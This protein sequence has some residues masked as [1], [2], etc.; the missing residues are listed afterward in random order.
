VDAAADTRWV[1]LYSPYPVADPSTLAPR[2]TSAPDAA[3]AL[4]AAAA[5]ISACGN[6]SAVATFA[7][8]LGVA[9]P[10]SATSPL[11]R[12]LALSEL[13]AATSVLQQRAAA[14]LALLGG[15]LAA[16]ALPAAP[17]AL[18]TNCSAQGGSVGAGV[19]LALCV[20]PDSAGAFPSA[21]DLLGR[22]SATFCAA[23]AGPSGL[24]VST[25]GAG[26]G[27][28]AIAVPVALLLL[29][30]AG[31]CWGYAGWR[32]KRVRLVEL[33]KKRRRLSM[34][35]MSAADVARALDG[36]GERDG[37]SGGGVKGDGGT[38]AARVRTL[39]WVGGRNDDRA[40]LAAIASSR[41]LARKVFAPVRLGGESAA[42]NAVPAEAVFSEVDME[43]ESVAEAPAAVAAEAAAVGPT[44]PAAEEPA[45]V[46]PAA[47]APVAPASPEPA[48]QQ[49][50]EPQ[51]IFVPSPAVVVRNPLSISVAT[52]VA[53]A[54]EEEEPRRSR[55]TSVSEWGRDGGGP[56]EVAP[57]RAP[58]MS[59]VQQL[60]E[61]I[62]P[63]S[64][65]LGMGL[66][67]TPASEEVGAG[68]NTRFSSREGPPAV[69]SAP[70]APAAPPPLPA[71][72]GG[73]GAERGAPSSAFEVGKI[74]TRREVV[75]QQVVQLRRV[76]NVKGDVVRASTSAFTA[77]SGR[78]LVVEERE[79]GK[80][81]FRGV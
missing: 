44:D 5:P 28:A 35:A 69:P 64:I 37:G 27:A 31:G 17:F 8:V 16:Q 65:S 1:W 67:D 22:D 48:K 4:A 46:E 62:V 20:Q 55:G 23:P 7:L 52:A 54:A 45:A 2:N 63:G 74:V 53:A 29:C 39:S 34:A 56:S 79:G 77:V 19:V 25:G 76:E 51:Q 49:E 66:S 57:A 75:Q 40:K 6:I 59:V 12:A 24:A 50:E 42:L 13:T 30:C 36:L 10:G 70:A 41:S 9:Q 11:A 72:R 21:S 80:R 73:A 47:A 38:D 3:A 68:A 43:A 60:C 18:T 58:Q 14:A 61:L 26:A 81:G 33:H 32:A 78:T 15:A 71:R